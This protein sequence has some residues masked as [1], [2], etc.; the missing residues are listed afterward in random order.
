MTAKESK[1]TLDDNPD[2]Y[3]ALLFTTSKGDEVVGLYREF[4]RA[5]SFENMS[6]KTDKIDE[7]LSDCDKYLDIFQNEVDTEYDFE[8][9]YYKIVELVRQTMMSDFPDLT[10]GEIQIDRYWHP[11]PANSIG[12]C[13]N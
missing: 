4:D 7:I 8:D 6:E 13:Y 10:F 12:I 1:I 9:G 11:H 5:E 2:S 3:P